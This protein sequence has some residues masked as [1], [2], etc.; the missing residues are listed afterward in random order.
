MLSKPEGDD[1]GSVGEPIYGSMKRKGSRKDK[2]SVEDEAK[3]AEEFARKEEEKRL[4][5]E[6][7]EQQKREKEELKAAE[8]ERVR[9]MI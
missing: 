6:A 4:K 5:K 8:K 9:Y 2:Y 1:D 3:A 7:K